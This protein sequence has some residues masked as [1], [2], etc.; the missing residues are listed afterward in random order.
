MSNSQPPNDSQPKPEPTVHAWSTDPATALLIFTLMERYHQIAQVLK[1]LRED[2][3]ARVQDL[4]SP[5]NAEG[6]ESHRVMATGLFNHLYRLLVGRLISPD[7]FCL[8]ITPTAAA[9][10]WN[11][12]A[13]LDADV[14]NAAAARAGAPPIPLGEHVVEFF[15]KH[16][17]ETG[18]LRIPTGRK[19]PETVN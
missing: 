1:V 16:Y 14:R 10:W 17:A 6:R 12:V 3:I 18:E 11:L 7:L 8:V 5:L 9:L 19:A 13:P 15:Y 4:M 2:R